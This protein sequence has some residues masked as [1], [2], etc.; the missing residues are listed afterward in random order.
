VLISQ[1]LVGCG[2]T[3]CGLEHA[4]VAGLQVPAVWHASLA[5]HVTPA[6]LQAPLVH[7]SFDV[8][9]F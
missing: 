6:P 9:A 7:W 8:Q 3:T 1:A 2:R 4:P 5:V